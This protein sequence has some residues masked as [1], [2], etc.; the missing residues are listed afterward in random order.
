MEEK[1][2]KKTILLVEDDTS[3]RELYAMAF[4]N[5][6]L[7]VVMAENGE[8]GLRLALEMHPALILLDIDMPLMNGH[9]VF[10]K[11]RTDSWGQT[12]AVI[13]LTNRD[14]ARDIAHANTRQPVD[15]VIKA[16]LPVKNVVN[17]VLAALGE[18][19]L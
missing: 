14:D 11:L 16:N 13:F 7:H 2:E 6:G 5:A 1:N 17:K 18:E 8:Q 9:E 15:Y 10:E 3:I 19:S 4:I 12:A